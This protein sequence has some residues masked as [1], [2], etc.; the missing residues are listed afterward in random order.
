MAA[1]NAYHKLESKKSS[2]VNG[3]YGD[4]QSSAPT[5]SNPFGDSGKRPATDI[6]VSEKISWKDIILDVAVI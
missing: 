4:I 2:E 5:D 3:G 1:A 6:H